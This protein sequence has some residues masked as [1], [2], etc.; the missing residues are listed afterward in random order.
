M[1]KFSSPQM[2]RLRKNII[3]FSKQ[4]GFQ[5]TFEINLKVTDFLDIY[6]DLENDKFYPYRKPNDTPFYVHRKSNH[7]LYI[8][9]QLPKMT[10][11]QIPNLS[12]NE[13]EFLTASGEYQ[14]V[15]KNSGF[16][17]KLVWTRSTQRNRRQR[18]RKLSGT[19]PLLIFRLKQTLPKHF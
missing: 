13:D 19:T 5:I 18:N 6:L 1:H 12:C 4:H 7:H 14:N 2:D 15:L 10:S 16:K 17:D 9:K 8:L 3:A 11:E